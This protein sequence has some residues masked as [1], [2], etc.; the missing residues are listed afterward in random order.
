[1]INEHITLGKYNHLKIDR[2]TEHGLFLKAKDNEGSVL[3][4][5]KYITDDMN[6][7]D[8]IKVFIYLDSNGKQIATTNEVVAQ[9]D[10]FGCFEVSSI[11]SFGAFMKWGVDKELLVPKSKQ[12]RPFYRGD[13]KILRIETDEETGRLIGVERVQKYLQKAS[14]NDLK[15]N[16]E[17]ELL[18][19]ASTPLGY[20]VIV[21]HLYEGMIFKN[22]IFQKV[23]IG[24]KLFGYI[25]T[26]RED[27]K[28]DLKLQPTG[29]LKDDLNSARVLGALATLGGKINI[30]SKSSPQEIEENFNM[31]KK[32]F[33]ATLVKLQKENKIKV[34]DGTT[35]II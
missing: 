19:I 11:S 12:K 24:D 31:S 9:L 20:K 32:S 13:K 1:L 33:K 25:K 2:D 29:E 23:S 18:V 16:Q 28:L 27:G 14:S 10:E 35:S 26:I 8:V 22:E 30:T 34:E 6:L 17:C 21:D 15:I 7:G 3:L 4:P 5:G